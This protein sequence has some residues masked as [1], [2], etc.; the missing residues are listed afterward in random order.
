MKKKLS[1]TIVI[2]TTT[3]IIIAGILLIA[4]ISRNVIV[5]NTAEAFNRQQ[6]FLVRE[7]ARGVEQL[8]KN[9]EVNLKTSSAVFDS[10]PR[11]KVLRALLEIRKN[12]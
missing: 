4:L 9:I 2:W 11:E 6:L 3:T 12:F 10:Y 1:S 8:L 7:S 5:K